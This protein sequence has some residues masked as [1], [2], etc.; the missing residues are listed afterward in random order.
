MKSELKFKCYGCKKS[1]TE[2]GALLFSP[3]SEMIGNNWVEKF[4]I[5]IKCY[6]KI[7]VF[8]NED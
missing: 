8:L 5:C 3:P 6:D 2:P 4:H 7:I 1:I